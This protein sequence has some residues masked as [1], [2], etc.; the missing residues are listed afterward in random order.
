[1]GPSP[2]LLQSLWLGVAF[3][4]AGIVL[5]IWA[6]VGFMSAETEIAPTSTSNKMLVVL[7]PYR[8]TRNPMYLG[9]ILLSFA[10]AF[11]SGRLL[12][13]AVPVLMFLLCNGL[14]IPFEETKMQRQF[15]NQYTNYIDRVRRWI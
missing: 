4:V 2:A 11:F 9:L 6:V 10:I 12:Y 5:A 1:V 3:A 8:F 7:G 13:F 14:F 15:G